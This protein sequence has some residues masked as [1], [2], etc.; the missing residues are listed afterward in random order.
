M[1]W[2]TISQAE[3]RDFEPIPVIC[4]KCQ[5]ELETSTIRSSAKEDI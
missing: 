3:G 2:L 5:I 4:L 1:D